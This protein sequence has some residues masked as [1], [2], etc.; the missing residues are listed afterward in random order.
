MRK[1]MYLRGHLISTMDAKSVICAHKIQVSSCT[2]V[3]IFQIPVNFLPFALV[4]PSPADN[5]VRFGAGAGA[6]AQRGASGAR[7]GQQV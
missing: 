4:D 3:L 5:S 6:G 7:H 1:F 2:F